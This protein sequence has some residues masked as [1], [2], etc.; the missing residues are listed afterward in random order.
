MPLEAIRSRMAETRLMTMF[1]DGIM[2]P[3]RLA[4]GLLPTLLGRIFGSKQITLI[5]LM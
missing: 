2:L 5:N 3:Q 4:Q 1:C